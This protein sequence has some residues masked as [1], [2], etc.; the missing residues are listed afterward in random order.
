MS[1]PQETY[2]LFSDKKKKISH[3]VIHAATGHWPEWP[4][5][6][7]HHI[8]G[9][10]LNNDLSNLCL[11]SNVEHSIAHNIGERNHFF[12]KTHTKETIAK[13]SGENNSNW[14][15]DDA[16]PHSKYIRI[17]KAKRGAIEE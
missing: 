4:A 5:E 10:P 2:S 16:P 11:M 6:V 8:D 14:K 3:I 1:R 7:V 17:W 9:N 13:L 12:G 15:G